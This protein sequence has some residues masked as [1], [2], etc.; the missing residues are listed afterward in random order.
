MFDL[1]AVVVDMRGLSI[2]MSAD[3]WTVFDRWE[4]YAIL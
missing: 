3:Y 4:A 1:N 2:G